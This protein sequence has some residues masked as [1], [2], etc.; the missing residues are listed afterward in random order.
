VAVWQESDGTL[1]H[2]LSNR[3]VA[4][5]GW[6]AAAR[7]EDSDAGDA[8]KPQVAMDPEGNAVA[9]WQQFDG[10]SDG[11]WSKRYGGESEVWSGAERIDGNDPRGAT[12]PKVAMDAGGT[13][14]VVWTQPDD[15]HISIWS[16]R[17]NT[18]FG[19]G[20]PGTIE[21]H[22]GGRGREPEVAMDPNGNA[23]AVWSQRVG[24]SD[25]IWSNR[26]TWRD[27]G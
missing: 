3:Y 17:Y 7:I 1:E 2:I 16:N 26:L 21:D 25:E 10:K 27:P 13:A 9:V 4:G 11:I 6:G 19:W 22:H 23:V 12:S 5:V 20:T 18:S 14:V 15:I 24:Q 8:L